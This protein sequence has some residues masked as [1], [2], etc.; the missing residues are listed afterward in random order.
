[1]ELVKCY[2]FKEGKRWSICTY[3]RSFT[4]S[5][6]ITITLPY[7]PTTVYTQYLLTSDDVRATN[8]IDEHVRIIEEQKNGF[9]R[10]F[11]F[12]LEPSRALVLVNEE[13]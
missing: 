13:Q 6:T 9:S 7:E 1:M 11:T 3:N 12:T 2:A 4:T 8:A 10:Q 5:Q